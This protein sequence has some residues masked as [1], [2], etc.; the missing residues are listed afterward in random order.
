MVL[1]LIRGD[2]AVYRAHTAFDNA[3][4]GINDAIAR[5]LQ[6]RDTSPLRPGAGPQR[7]KIV[8]F[9]P[10][11]NLAKVADALFEAGAGKIGAYSQCS[12]RL[13]G[14]GTFFGS[15]TTRPGL[16]QKGQREEVGEW[17]LVYNAG[18]QM[19][20]FGSSAAAGQRWWTSL[21][22]DPRCIREERSHGPC[23]RPP[24]DEL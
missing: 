18:C 24:A 14:T 4:G 7:F 21:R 13:A 3:P 2:V 16:G 17:R 9:V 19:P 8:V 1:N 5:L 11:D 15:K 23:I 22:G 10:P 12:F 6:L 20:S